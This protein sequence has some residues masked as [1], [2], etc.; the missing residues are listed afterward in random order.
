MDNSQSLKS[1]TCPKCGSN[2]IYT[3]KGKNARGVRT[4]NLISN[5]LFRID[6]FMCLKCGHFEEFVNE[7]ELTDEKM[8]KGIVE[9]SIK[10]NKS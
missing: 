9:N 5:L 4:R 7:S 3:D 2:E 10:V 6:T 8:I 1:G